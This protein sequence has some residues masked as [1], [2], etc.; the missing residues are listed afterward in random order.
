MQAAPAVVVKVLRYNRWLKFLFKRPRYAGVSCFKSFVFS[1]WVE[2]VVEAMDSQEHRPIFWEATVAG[3][4]V[5]A[6]PQSLTQFLVAV[7]EAGE[8]FYF[9]KRQ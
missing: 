5:L 9:E 8:V 7:V 6:S 4:A 1:F 3:A 2:A